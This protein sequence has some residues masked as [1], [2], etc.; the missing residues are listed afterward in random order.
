MPAELEP[1]LPSD[2][3]LLNLDEEEEFC[4]VR[5]RVEP[6]ADPR[7]CSREP[8]DASAVPKAARLRI[9]RRVGRQQAM[10]AMLVSTMVQKRPWEVM[11][12]MS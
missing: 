9:G 12:M 2:T 10:R 7:P 6:S 11:P 5:Q 1:R 3:D 4:V 8:R